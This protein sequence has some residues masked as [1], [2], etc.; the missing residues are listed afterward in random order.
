VSD[1]SDIAV[2]STDVYY[3]EFA[4]VDAVAK[5]PLD[6]GKGGRIYSVAV[7]NSSAYALALDAMNVYWIANIGDPSDTIALISM[8]KAG[9]TPATLA[10]GNLSTT[11]LAVDAKNVYFSNGSLVS[12]PL[13]G[14]ALTTLASAT[15]TIGAIAV[16]STS[17]YYTVSGALMRLVKP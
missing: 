4:D 2:D 15:G 5:I 17:V 13:A 10:S 12:V 9:G 8:P 6:G 16:D 14:G 7:T 3:T 1:V 11:A